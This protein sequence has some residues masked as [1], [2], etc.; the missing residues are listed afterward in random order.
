[1]QSLF[2]RDLTQLFFQIPPK[3]KKANPDKWICLIGKQYHNIFK[4]SKTCHILQFIRVIKHDWNQ[5]FKFYRL[6]HLCQNM[7]GD[8]KF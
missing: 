5:Q 2:N 1:M 6:E 7:L 8:D 3:I 4:L